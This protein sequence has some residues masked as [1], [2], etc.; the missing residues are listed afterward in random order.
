M[1][2]SLVRL[3]SAIVIK[4]SGAFPSPLASSFDPF[5][6]VAGRSDVA[7]VD[8][9]QTRILLRSCYHYELDSMF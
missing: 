4:N 3:I 6:F 7:T 8:A 9:L 1:V 2:R 5:E